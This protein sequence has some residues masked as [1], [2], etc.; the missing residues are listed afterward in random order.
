M[1]VGAIIVII[2]VLA[3]YSGS[4]KEDIPIHKEKVENTFSGV[5]DQTPN[6]TEVEKQRLDT[7]FQTQQKINQQ[8]M[9]GMSKLESEN[10]KYHQAEIQAESNA[11]LA[12][13]KIAKLSL[14]SHPITKKA[15]LQH[16]VFEDDINTESE[17]PEKN[18]S[19]NPNMQSVSQTPDDDISTYIPSN[20]FVKGILISS[21]SANTGGNADQTPTPVLIRLTDLAQL[22]NSFRSNI[23]SCM[24]GGTGYGDLSTERVKIRL[25]TLSCI[26]KSGKAVDI[27]VSGYIAGEDAKAGIKGLVVTHSGS[28]AAKAALA[29]FLQGVGTVGQAMGQTQTVT[30]I[31]GVTTTISPDQALY[32]G[33]GAGVSQVGSTLSQ[34]YMRMLEQISPAIEVS[35]KR[36]VTV[37]FTEG[38]KFKLPINDVSLSDEPLPLEQE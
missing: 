16:T 17:I 23:K 19:Q 4:D 27:Q 2:V 13:E 12:N 8:L 36:H 14:E 5:K 6:A 30:P 26:L 25:T 24:V 29:G 18:V 37:I 21:L 1:I 11:I 35:S 33:G 10:Q 20:S 32:A 9:D 15:A 3:I 7:M 28:V 34:Y 31:G 38:I 22:P